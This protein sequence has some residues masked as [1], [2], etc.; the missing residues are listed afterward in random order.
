M[1]APVPG[2]MAWPA[3]EIPPA[4]PALV[5]RGRA[6]SGLVVMAIVNRTDDSF[7]PAARQL[8]DNVALEAAERAAQEG[9]QILD[10]GGVRAGQ[11]P[12][13]SAAQEIERV[14][15]FVERVRA[16]VPDLLISVDT[17][18]AEVARAVIDAGADLINDTWSGYD[19]ELVAVAGERGVGVVCSHTGGAVPR[20]DAVRASYPALPGTADPRDGVVQDVVATVTAGA[21]RARECGVP[22]ESILVDPTL[23]FGK[24]TWHSL[25][26]LRRT[27]VLAGLGYPVLMALSRKD[28]IGE[29]LDLPVTERL[30]GTLAATALAAWFGARVFRAHDVAATRRVLDMVEVIRDDAPPAHVVR[31]MT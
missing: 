1:S 11:G 3:L 25:H 18:R 14:V 9:A 16:R 5:L 27:C 13:V 17:W 7:Y 15:P 6:L 22:A 12:P 21:A 31:G 23:D 28:F 29:S 2:E 19:P 26:L 20:S 4:S 30:E 10:I 8:D 24:N